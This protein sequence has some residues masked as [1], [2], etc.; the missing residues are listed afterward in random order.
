MADIPTLHVLRDFDGINIDEAETPDFL[1]YRPDSVELLLVDLVQRRYIVG[2]F[3]A[4]VQPVCIIDQNKCALSGA[5]CRVSVFLDPFT[6]CAL[7]E[8]C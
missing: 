7:Y 8:A 2:P 3:P 5:S 6:V 4:Y 1:A